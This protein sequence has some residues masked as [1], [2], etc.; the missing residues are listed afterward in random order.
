MEFTTKL[1]DDWEPGKPVRFQGPHSP[2]EVDA[3]KDAKPGMTLRY[4]LAP[5]YEFRAEVPPDVKAGEEALFI[6]PD[7]V[8]IAVRVP[9]NLKAGD[10]FEILPPAL[11]VR[12]PEGVSPGDA[13]VFRHEFPGGGEWLRTKVPPVLTPGKYFAARIPVPN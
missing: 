1:S 3:P 13:V 12:V 9:D 8:T 11:M 2:I 7:G 4:R 6:R 10:I 5:H